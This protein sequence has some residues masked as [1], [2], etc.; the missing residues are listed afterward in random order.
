MKTIEVRRHAPSDEEKNVSPE[1]LQLAHD[2]IPRLRD[3]YDAY[4]CSPQKRTA[5]TMAAFGFEGATPRDGFDT[6]PGDRMKPFMPQVEVL[7]AETRC[8]LITA[9]VAV[10]DIRAILEE[11]GGKFLDGVRKVAAELAEGGCALVVSHGGTIEP[12]VMAARGDWNVAAMGGPL[13]EC[14]AAIFEV[15]GEDVVNVKLDRTT[16]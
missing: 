5:Q 6:L 14:E 13:K 16:L 10:D 15:E 2:M 7:M 11:T 9:F 3:S 12:A 4:Y 1:G 8:D